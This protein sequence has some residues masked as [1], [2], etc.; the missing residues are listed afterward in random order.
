MEK[1]KKKLSRG[2]VLFVVLLIILLAVLAFSLYKIIPYVYSLK[3]AEHQ[4]SDLKDTYVSEPEESVDTEVPEDPDAWWYTDVKVDVAG[5]RETNPDVMGWIRFDDTEAAA[6]DYPVLAA[7]G[8]DE[9]LRSDMEHKYSL[10]GSIFSMDEDSLD[11]VYAHVL[12]YGHN[13]RD[14]SM[15]S[16]LVKYEDEAFYREN[17]YFTVYTEKAAYR[18]EIFS[19]FTADVDGD[20]YLTLHERDEDYEEYLQFLIDSSEYDTGIVPDINDYTISLSTCT[21]RGY[22]WR[23]TIH[24]VCIDRYD[25]E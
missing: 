4:F 1:E 2:S 17:R 18:Y 21:D 15:F 3:K 22:D 23:Y 24:A 14:G 11:R 16:S 13:M 5:L 12:L 9:Y 20:V 25:Y 6:I 8:P 10:P 7:D 19:C